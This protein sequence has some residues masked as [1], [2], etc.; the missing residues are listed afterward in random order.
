M[1]AA[2]FLKRLNALESIGLILYHPV[3]FDSKKGEVIAE[4]T[5]PFYEGQ[6]YAEVIRQVVETAL[7]ES[8]YRDRLLDYEYV[9]PALS[10]IK[11]V[12][13]YGI[14]YPRYRQK[15]SLTSAGYAAVH[16]RMENTLIQLEGLAS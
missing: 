8:N 10:H 16:E 5:N 15:T 4:L 1:I 3:L 14:V 11:E 13:L 7:P 2:L 12:C 6:D 9:I